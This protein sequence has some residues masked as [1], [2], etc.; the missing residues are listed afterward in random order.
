MGNVKAGI[1]IWQRL[2]GLVF[3]YQHPLGYR[4][5]RMMARTAGLTVT[6]AGLWGRLNGAPRCELSHVT[7]LRQSLRRPLVQ[8]DARH[9]GRNAGFGMNL[10]R[11]PQQQAA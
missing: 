11:H 3:L 9:L 1:A 5:M 8:T 4:V 2:F 7:G 6:A 10:G